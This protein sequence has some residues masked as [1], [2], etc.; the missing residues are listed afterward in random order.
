MRKRYPR[1]KAT[2]D[3]FE[4]E[5]GPPIPEP[6]SYETIYTLQG[7]LRKSP[8]EASLEEE[9]RAERKRE[10]ARPLWP[11][12]SHRRHSLRCSIGRSIRCP[13]S[14]ERLSERPFVSLPA[15]GYRLP[16]ISCT[17]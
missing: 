9:R 1:K 15:T 4:K 8:L 14:A 5:R 17:L 7:S 12:N 2:P 6:N 11:L 3:M 13:L 10:N 16:A